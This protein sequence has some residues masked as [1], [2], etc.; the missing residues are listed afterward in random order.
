MRVLM[1][2]RQFH[3]YVGGLESAVLALARQLHIMG[4]TVDIVTLNRRVRGTELGALARHGMVGHLAV[5]RV[6]SLSRRYAMP[7]WIPPRRD[8]D[9]IHFHGIDGFLEVWRLLGYGG[10]PAVLST[11]GLIFHTSRMKSLKD[12]YWQHAFRALG[13]RLTILASSASDQAQLARI[14]LLAQVMANPVEWPVGVAS[15]PRDPNLLLYLG[16][17]AE[18]KGIADLMNV[19]RHLRETNPEVRLTLAGEDW[20][21]TLARLQPLPDGVTWIGRVPDDGKYWLIRQA[22]AA[23]FPSQAEGFGIGVVEA[24]AQGTPVVAQNNPAYRELIH[25]GEN[26]FLVDFKQVE[27]TSSQLQQLLG[28]AQLAA[29]IS[30]KARASVLQYRPED[31]ARQI[32]EVYQNLL[33]V[34]YTPLSLRQTSQGSTL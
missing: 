6:P 19:F 30:A 23:V 7:V 11:H 28:D 25:S 13:Q 12:W 22:G 27:K 14:G 18:H 24:L 21:G 16:R 8:Y 33:K 5:T 31:I 1:V 32:M 9:L 4:I 26:G 20:D 15:S 2:V 10:I 3:P 17:I 34:P 29:R